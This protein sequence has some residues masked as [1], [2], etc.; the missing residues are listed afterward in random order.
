VPKVPNPAAMG[1]HILP[2]DIGQWSVPA[3]WV[4][5]PGRRKGARPGRR[6]GASIN[7]AGRG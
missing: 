7:G 2:Y 4:Q 1:H 5:R 6:K 3:W